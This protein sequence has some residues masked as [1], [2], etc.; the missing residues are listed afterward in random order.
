MSTWTAYHNRSISPQEQALYDHL[1]AYAEYETPGELIERFQSLFV[2]GVGYPSRKIVDTLDEILAS[3]DVEQ[4]FHYVLNRC[5]HILV[6][7]WQS[8]SQFQSAV[9][10]FIEVLE[11]GPTKHVTEY[12]RSR[13]VRKL[14]EIVAEFTE[15]EQYL[16]L[17]RLARLIDNREEE[18][19]DSNSPLGTLIQRYPYLYEHCLV[20]EGSPE[21]HQRH[22]RRIQRKAQHKF[23]VNLS[24]YVTY[25][26]RRARLEKQRPSQEHLQRLRPIANPTL[27][28]D[29]ELVASLNQFSGKVDNGHSYCDSAQIFLKRNQAVRFA[30]FK[31]DLYHYL[32]DTIDSS[33]SRRKFSNLLSKQLKET[34]PQ[35]DEQ[36][37]NDFLLVRTCSQLLSFLVVES[38]QRPHHFV[39]VDLI[40]NLGPLLTTSLLLKLVLLC[41]R[42]KP[43]LERRFSIL[44]NHYEAAAQGNVLWLVKMFE[45]LNIALSLTFGSVDI[46]SVL[47]A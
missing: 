23:E 7:R 47:S 6:N 20:G 41:R 35:N 24:H 42:V 29:R 30:D 16:T 2:D 36:L 33:Y 46:S 8:R 13:Q 32:S 4:Y 19:S 11:K 39:F 9:P 45:S 37:L 27:L 22:I 1:L 28:S 31:G 18:C 14:R 12:S 3:K 25:R 43:Y 5:C 38:P 34:L 10:T 21:E 40:N 17:K 15:T 26:V 44:F